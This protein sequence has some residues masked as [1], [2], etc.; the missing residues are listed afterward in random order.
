V[1]SN[2]CRKIFTPDN[3]NA[4][5]W[6]AIFDCGESMSGRVAGGLARYALFLF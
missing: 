5:V 1:L 6:E 4:S 3:A 2:A